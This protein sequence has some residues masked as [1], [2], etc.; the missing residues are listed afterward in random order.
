MV[1]HCVGQAGMATRCQ[2]IASRKL[3]D[4]CANRRV[5]ITLLTLLAKISEV[6]AKDEFFNIKNVTR[7]DVLAAH[8]VP[9]Q[10]LGL[11]P[12]GTTGFGSVVPAAQVFAVN[13]LVPLQARLRELNDWAGDEIVAFDPYSIA[14]MSS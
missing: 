5:G 14:G 1:N 4:D 11:V 6:A 8:R 12:T 3:V 7:D 9:P 10:L 2:I 13:E